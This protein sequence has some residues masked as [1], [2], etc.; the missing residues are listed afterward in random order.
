MGPEGIKP[1]TEQDPHLIDRQKRLDEARAEVETIG[2]ALGK[3]IDEGIK[4]GIAV[5]R[6]LGINTTGSCEGHENW[7]TGAPYI[8]IESKET[9]VLFKKIESLPKP[10]DPDAENPERDTIRREILKKNLEERKKLI[11]LLDEFY[12]DRPTLYETRLHI[13]GL[14][15]GWGRLENQGVDFQDTETDMAKKKEALSRFQYEMQE[16]LAFAKKK[17]FEGELAV[18]TESE[19]ESSERLPDVP[20][21]R[22]LLKEL[23]FNDNIAGTWKYPFTE[24]SKDLNDGNQDA[25]VDKYLNYII[26]DGGAEKFKEFVDALRPY[27]DSIRE[28][29]AYPAL[30]RDLLSI[31]NNKTWTG[32]DK[33][34]SARVFGDVEK[35]STYIWNGMIRAKEKTEDEPQRMKER[36]QRTPLADADEINAGIYYEELEPQVSD[37]VFALRKKGY[38]TFQ[39][40][41][42]YSLEKGSQFIDFNKEDAEFIKDILNNST[43]KESL[44]ADGVLIETEDHDD[45]LS[46]ILN[47]INPKHDLVFWKKIWD[48]FAENAPDRGFRATPPIELGSYKTFIERQK[49]I[50][51]GKKTYVGYGLQYDAGN[52]VESKERNT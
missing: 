1:M 10:E 17:F 23:F 51:N 42:Y 35:F 9:E 16:F 3:P 13:S 45:R 36:L 7:G 24:E 14:G 41:I 52:I 31:W 26:E 6:A 4:E 18:E 15:N 38:G 30:F 43:I 40:G 33:F 47:P 21:F 25:D 37:A 11:P 34:D 22:A 8:D 48:S 20:E 32:D 2:D 29:G 46:L 12:R 27:F 39:S 44:R 49:A 28:I 5:F 50:R 19:N